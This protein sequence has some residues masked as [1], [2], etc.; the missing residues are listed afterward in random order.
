[1]NF[2]DNME[3]ANLDYMS[4]FVIEQELTMIKSGLLFDD[5]K[6]NY[7]KNGNYQ[8]IY[9]IS[10]PNDSWYYRTENPLY[11]SAEGLEKYFKNVMYICSFVS[12]IYNCDGILLRN[13]P[14]TEITNQ[15]IKFI[16]QLQILVY[17]KI[18]NENTEYNY[19]TYHKGVHS[20]EKFSQKKL[21][22]LE[23]LVV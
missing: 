1:M 6:F 21:E 5:F 23:R 13:I 18:R 19:E 8:E 20:F 9:Y 3:N 22:E 7:S 12:S 14:E 10:V 15:A 2:G 17:S 11:T 4:N 16:E